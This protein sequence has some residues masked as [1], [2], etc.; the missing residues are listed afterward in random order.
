MVTALPTAAV[1]GADTE[2]T[3]A[4]VGVVGVAV[5]HEIT[6]FASMLKLEQFASEKEK[7]AAWP[8]PAMSR[9]GAEAAKAIKDFIDQSSIRVERRH[10]PDNP[11]T[12]LPQD[13][14]PAAGGFA[15]PP[16]DGFAFTD[17]VANLRVSTAMVKKT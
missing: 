4:V 10:H 15:S 11:A 16:F 6:P 7:D 8:T 12:P 2:Q 17:D 1:A 14:R 9:K 13:E 5:T 3:G